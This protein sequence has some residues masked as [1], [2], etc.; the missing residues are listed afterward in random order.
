MAF[1]GFTDDSFDFLDELTLNNNREWFHAN[2]ARYQQ[3]VQQPLAELF[4]ELEPEF[5]TPKL[6]RIYRDTRFSADKSP[7][8]TAAAGMISRGNGTTWYAQISADGL[9]VGGGAPHLDAVQLAGYRRAV[10]EPGGAEMADIVEGLRAKGLEVGTLTG[11]GLSETPDLKRVPKP[12]PQDHDRSA[13]LRYKKLVAVNR[14]EVSPALMSPS[15]VP[16]VAESWRTMAPLVD[17][18]SDAIRT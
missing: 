8:K 18:L 4:G 17:W 5:G 16:L 3:S 14:C 1:E 2:K 6:F 11:M 10:G 12:W 7:Y 13:L 15:V 9:M